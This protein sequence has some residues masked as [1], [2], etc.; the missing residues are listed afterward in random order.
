MSLQSREP[1][2]IEFPDSPGVYVL[3]L[4]LPQPL[5]LRVGRLGEYYFQKGIYLYIGSA[6]GPGGLRARIS[7]HLDRDKSLHWHIDWLR[8]V[9]KVRGVFY[10][11]TNDRLECSWSQALIK[12]PAACVTAPGFGSSDCRR[13]PVPCESHLVWFGSDAEGIRDSLPKDDKLPVVYHQVA[14]HNFPEY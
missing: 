14:G 5:H 9:A 2:S 12:L 3:H 7:R 11:V 6:L 8:H 10:T 4:E 1:H 13:K